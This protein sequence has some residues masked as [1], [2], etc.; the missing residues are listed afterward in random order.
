MTQINI[1][2]YR[3]NS[4]TSYTG[5]S[6][7]NLA[8]KECN[9]DVFDNDEKNY[10]LIIPSG[11]TAFNPSFFLGFFFDSI[12]ALGLFEFE[13]KYTIHFEDSNE[14]R[15]SRIARDIEEG[16]RHAQNQLQ[17]KT[18]FFNFLT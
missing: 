5:R 1:T 4:R 7:G 17:P 14:S 18:G 15:N 16:K 6:E 8:R 12:K 11:T 3:G 10:T 13:K 9:L 2:K